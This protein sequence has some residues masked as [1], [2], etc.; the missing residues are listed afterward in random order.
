MKFASQKDMDKKINDILE[1]KHAINFGWIDYDRLKYFRMRETENSNCQKGILVVD[2]YGT[3]L[4]TF[5][6]ISK[7]NDDVPP[8]LWRRFISVKSDFY[9]INHKGLEIRK[10]RVKTLIGLTFTLVK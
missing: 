8:R 5:D 10:L 3:H 7:S 4:F 1:K 9:Y 6:D 2:D